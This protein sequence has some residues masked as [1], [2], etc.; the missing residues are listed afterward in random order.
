MK[1]QSLVLDLGSFA[2]IRTASSTILALDRPVD[3]VI[4]NAG[5]MMTP[6]GKTV[7]GFETQFG[8]NHVG[9]FLFTNLIMPKLLEAAE[10]KNEAVIVNVSSVGHRYSPVRWDDIGFSDGKAYDR[11]QAYGQSK[12]ANILFSLALKDKLAAKGIRSYSLHPGG[13]QSPIIYQLDNSRKPG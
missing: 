6:Y 12:T 13:E 1:T 2:S 4:N 9:H 3:V 7:D 5:V 8:V 11:I 10:K